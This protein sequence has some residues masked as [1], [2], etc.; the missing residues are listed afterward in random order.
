M[1]PGFLSHIMELWVLF[2]YFFLLLVVLVLP[3]F[4]SLC[5]VLMPFP[6]CIPLS[7]SSYL[8]WSI[9]SLVF[10]CFTWKVCFW[11]VS[12]LFFILSLWLSASSSL[13]LPVS[14][15]CSTCSSVLLPNYSPCPCQPLCQNT[16][17]CCSLFFCHILLQ[18]V[19]QTFSWSSHPSWHLF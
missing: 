12:F 15:T 6:S 10:S 11:C 9:M 13:S 18:L 8:G 1:V 17:L 3:Y 4:A 19:A 5:F 14:F 2:R 16:C 7:L